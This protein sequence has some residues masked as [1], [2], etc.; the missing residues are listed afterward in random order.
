M[1]FRTI[2]FNEAN[3]PRS[4]WRF[5]IFFFLFSLLASLANLGLFGLL[6]IA[7]VSAEP[8]TP[9]FLLANSLVSIVTVALASWTCLVLLERLPFKA[10]GISPERGFLRD[11]GLGAV[12]GAAAY[13]VATAL[14]AAGG[15]IGFSGNGEAGKVAVLASMGYSFIVLLSAAVFEELLFRGY[16]LQTFTRSGNA[17]PAIIGTSILFGMAHAGNPNVSGIAILNTFLAGIWFGVAWLR[18]DSLW[19][20]I[21]LHVSWNWVQGNVF[22]VEISGL[23]TLITAPLM[24]ETDSGPA[25]LTGGDYGIEGGIGCTAAL[26]VSIAALWFVRKAESGKR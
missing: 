23:T 11:L 18:T 1:K 12:L 19:L 15:G 22:G 24:R 20:P 26:A 4:G 16:M 13:V 14:S 2:F 21:G 9:S 8:D 5:L 17:W 25:W 10:L 7:G 6:S 3:V